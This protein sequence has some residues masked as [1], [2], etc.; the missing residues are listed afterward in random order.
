MLERTAWAESLESQVADVSRYCARNGGSV[1]AG[2]AGLGAETAGPGIDT[3]S[4]D[5]A[6][7]GLTHSG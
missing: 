3:L 2:E 6:T 7:D 5:L 4:G 1:G